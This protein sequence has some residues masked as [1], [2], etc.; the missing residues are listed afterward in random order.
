MTLNQLRERNRTAADDQDEVEYEPVFVGMDNLLPKV[1]TDW[2]SKLLGSDMVRQLQDS[3]A[4]GLTS[5]TQGTKPILPYIHGL[6][7]GDNAFTRG[8]Y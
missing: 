5:A 2:A 8:E 7:F 1:S 6:T 4:Y 3:A